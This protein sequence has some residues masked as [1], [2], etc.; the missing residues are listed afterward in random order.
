MFYKQLIYL[1]TD[2]HEDDVTRE[3][4]MSNFRELFR[5]IPSLPIGIV[6]EPLVKCIVENDGRTYNVNV[7]DFDFFILLCKHPKLT[8][9]PYGLHIMDLMAKLYLQYG[10][11]ASSALIPL[12]ILST[13][14]IEEGECQDFIGKFTSLALSSFLS[15]KKPF[16][17]VVKG[18]ELNLPL[19]DVNKHDPNSIRKIKRYNVVTWVKKVVLELKISEEFNEGIKE[20]VLHTNRRYKEYYGTMCR[21]LI[22]LLEIWEPKPKKVAQDYIKQKDD[23]DR[24]AAE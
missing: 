11:W 15:L 9:I 23:E 21:G 19:A 4:M 16:E 7:F 22:H 18:K 6:I 13:R 1:L 12:M 24:V 8:F 14:F 20:Q 3:L 2:N 17:L 5:E 10:L